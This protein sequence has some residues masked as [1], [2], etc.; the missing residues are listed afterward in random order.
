V[1]IEYVWAEI[2]DSDAQLMSAYKRFRMGRARFSLIE[3]ISYPKPRI[4]ILEM[5]PSPTLILGL[6][7]KKIK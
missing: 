4:S 1:E 5:W 2:G 3:M 7:S 6:F